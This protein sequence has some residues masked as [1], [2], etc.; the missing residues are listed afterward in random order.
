MKCNDIPLRRLERC[1]NGLIICTKFPDQSRTKTPSNAAKRRGAIVEGLTG[2]RAFTSRLEAF[3]VVPFVQL[4][5]INGVSRR[6]DCLFCV[7]FCMS[8]DAKAHTLDVSSISAVKPDPPRLFSLVIMSKFAQEGRGKGNLCG[9]F[10]K[11]FY[12]FIL[13]TAHLKTPQIQISF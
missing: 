8:N 7:R 6:R 13:I 2:R 11:M 1:S 4:C 3:R 12:F 10:K 9:C 5:I